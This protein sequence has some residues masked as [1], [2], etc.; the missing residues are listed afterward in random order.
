MNTSQTS[1]TSN[2]AA[3]STPT[4]A[5]SPSWGAPLQVAAASLAVVFAP[6][7]SAATG[8]LGLGAIGLNTLQTERANSSTNEA[9]TGDTSA[10][11]GSVSYTDPMGN[12]SGGC[13]EIHSRLPGQRIASEVSVGDTLQLSDEQT[14]ASATGVVSYSERKTAAGF[15]ITTDNGVTLVCSDSAPIPTRDQGLILAPSLLGKWVA[16]R[17]DAGGTT[18]T[19]WHEVTSVESLGRIEVQHITVG[20]K[21]F[22]AGEKAHAYIL[23][24]NMKAVDIVGASPVEDWWW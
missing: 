2:P 19:E 15:R 7:V 17:I 8:L 4:Q 14:L 20:D 11:Y 13:V 12:S 18:R 21:C 22:W 5:S 1:P 16:T 3:V 24:H 9:S 10:T 23:H 6:A